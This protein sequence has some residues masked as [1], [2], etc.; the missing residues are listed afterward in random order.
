MIRAK[1]NKLY[2]CQEPG[3]WLKRQAS[4]FSVIL[5]LTLPKGASLEN[6]ASVG[7]N[8]EELE[9]HTER[10][11]PSRSSKQKLL[12]SIRHTRSFGWGSLMWQGLHR[13][14]TVAIRLVTIWLYPKHIPCLKTDLCSVSSRDPFCW[15]LLNVPPVYLMLRCYCNHLIPCLSVS[16]PDTVVLLHLLLES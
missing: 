8:H 10:H 4:Q 1:R 11:K 13:M 16:A 5:C 6:T 14:S 2:G 15:R 12:I 7:T 3:G 9:A